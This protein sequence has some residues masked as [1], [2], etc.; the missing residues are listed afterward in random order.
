MAPEGMA[1]QRKVAPKDDVLRGAKDI[2]QHTGHTVR[3]VFY[4]A[5]SKIIP[6]YKEG[7]TW[8]MRKSTYEAHIERLENEAIQ[9]K[10][11]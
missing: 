6:A 11:A 10:R 4:L 1:V 2:S 8:C 5:E 7:A 9:G 3:Q